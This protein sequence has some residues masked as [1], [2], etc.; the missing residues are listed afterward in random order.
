MLVISNQANITNPGDWSEKSQN[1][2]SLN[3]ESHTLI[4]E[5]SQNSFKNL[6]KSNLRM[7][8][9][10]KS[11]I[12]IVFLKHISSGHINYET[13]TLRSVMT[14]TRQINELKNVIFFIDFGQIYKNLF[15]VIS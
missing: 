5:S 7:I 4:Y 15:L 1:T 12:M 9:K 13:A 2:L 3:Q 11:S 6:S 14:Q 8:Q 10:L